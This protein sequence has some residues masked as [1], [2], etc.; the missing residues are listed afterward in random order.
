MKCRSKADE[1]RMIADVSFS[2]ERISLHNADVRGVP[3]LR[4]FEWNFRR[5]AQTFGAAPSGSRRFWA[6]LLRHAVPRLDTFKPLE[7]G[8]P[9]GIRR[10]R[11]ASEHAQG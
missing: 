3:C 11:G 6:E 7:L 1:L 4:S 9:S 10:R 8:S 2:A 5:K